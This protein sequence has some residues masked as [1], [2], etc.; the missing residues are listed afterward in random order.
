MAEK[1]FATIAYVVAQLGI[2]SG[3]ILLAASGARRGECGALPN[4]ARNVNGLAETPKL[5]LVKEFARCADIACWTQACPSLWYRP[6]PT[7]S[8]RDARLAVR[9]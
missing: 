2:A 1:I 4:N 7:S 5:A 8:A 6:W 3:F 9:A